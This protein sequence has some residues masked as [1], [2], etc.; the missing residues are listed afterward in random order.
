[1]VTMKKLFRLTTT[2]IKK[3][4]IKLSIYSFLVAALIVV[5]GLAQLIVNF[6]ASEVIQL[7]LNK[8]DQNV[9]SINKKNP[10]NE[11]INVVDETRIIDI[12]KDDIEK[13]KSTEYD[14][15]ELV[16]VVLDYGKY[17]SHSL[18]LLFYELPLQHFFCYIN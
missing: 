16:N 13:F 9:L 8:M 1:M 4:I 7:E 11:L 2:F 6:N 12:T 18:L 10:N 3:D 14:I 15:Y 17:T 5:L